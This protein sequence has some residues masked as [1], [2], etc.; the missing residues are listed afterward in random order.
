[1]KRYYIKALLMICIGILLFSCDKEEKTPEQIEREEIMAYEDLL[2]DHQWGFYDMSVSVQYESN[3]PPLLANVAD[4]NGKVQPG[5]YDSYII[6]GNNSRQLYNTYT[7]LRDDIMLDTNYS[8]NSFRI[9]GYYV[10]NTSKININPDSSLSI[11]FDYEYLEEENKFILNASSVYTEDFISRVNNAIIQSILSGTPSNIAGAVVEFLQENENVQ[12]AIQGFLYDLIHGK[13]EEITQSPEELAEELASALVQKLGEVDWESLL[14]ESIL[15]LLQN[16]PEANPEEKATELA[17]RMAE[18]IEASLTQSDIY[19]VLLPVFE[20]FENETLP[21]LASQLAAAA[22]QKIAEALSE[23]N[24]YERIY[25]VWEDLIEADTITVKETADT[26]AG[27]ATA[28]FFDSDTLTDKL[29]PFVQKIEDTPSLKLSQLAQ[30][31]IDSVLIPAVD[32]INEAF[33]GL[34]LEPDW[35]SV[36]PLITSLLTAIK[37]GLGSSTVEELAGSLADGIIGIMDLIIQKGFEKAIYSLQDI[38]PEQAASVIA[39]WI[40]SLVKMVEQPVVDFIEGKLDAIFDQFE[41]QKA[42]EELSTAIHAKVIDLFS[43][44]NL[45]QLFLP[46]LEVLSDAD[47]ERIAKVLSRLISEAGLIPEDLNEEQLT[48]AL[49]G[50][51]GNLIGTIDPDEATE[52]LLTLLLDNNLVKNLDGKILIQVLETKIYE[53]LYTIAGDV[54]AIDNIEIIIQKK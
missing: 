14:Y 23:E 41:A 13:V 31:I 25:P 27:I 10:I 36:K 37:A 43:E 8:G 29:I 47:M 45:Y 35:T 44:E 53:L 16:L 28:R 54:N 49:T 40:T 46:I 22:Y 30:E 33:P 11:K 26:L 15:A 51:L 39:S 24:L 34:G 7:F 17:Q 18:K 21:V 50:L 1:M 38:P 12:N 6:F 20:D 42:A 3:A 19:N 48:E 5:V 32:D 2:R 4:E 9:A 52:K